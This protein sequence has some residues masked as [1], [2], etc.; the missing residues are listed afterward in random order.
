MNEASD[1][2]HFRPF[3]TEDQQEAH[4]LILAGLGDHFPVIDQSLNPD[5]DDINGAYIA[6]GHL[7]MVA[8]LDGLIVGTGALLNL[9]N[10]VGRMVRV[11][12]DEGHRRQGIGRALVNYLVTIAKKRRFTRILVETN[13]DWEEAIALYR[14]CGFQPYER[15]EI[16]VHLQLELR[17]E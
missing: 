13:H 2:L 8:V 14:S 7:F 5:L 15:D 12:V 17:N 4:E 6:S 9:E 1:D 10:H 3:R 11:S 16:S